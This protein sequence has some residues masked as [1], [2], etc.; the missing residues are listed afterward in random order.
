MR[1]TLTLDDDAAGLIEEA[2][3]RRDATFKQVVNE[4]LRLGLKALEA[5]DSKP[6]P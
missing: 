3:A 5:P 2:R 4:A 1:T 6:E